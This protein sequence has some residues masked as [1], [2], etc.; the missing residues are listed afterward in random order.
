MEEEDGPAGPPGRKRSLARNLQ[1]LLGALALL[2]LMVLT[3]LHWR[4]LARDRGLEGYISLKGYALS[5]LQAYHSLLIFAGAMV[6]VPLLALALKAHE[7]WKLRDFKRML[8]RRRA[9]RK[10]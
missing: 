4:Q 3:F 5:Y 2:G 9:S 1:E 10:E 7:R 8:E 6:A